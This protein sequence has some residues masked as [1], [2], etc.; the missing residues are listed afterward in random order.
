[1]PDLD[2]V[3]FIFRIPYK[4]AFGHR[5]ISHSIAFA[6]AIAFLAFWALPSRCREIPARRWLWTYLFLATVSHGVLDAFTNGG[7]GIAFFAPFDYDRYFFPVTPIEVSPLGVGFFS[8]RGFAVLLSEIQWVWLPSLLFALAAFAIRSG[9]NTR[10]NV[11]HEP[12]T[13]R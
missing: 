6:V 12:S 4:S 1:M 2:V 3:S 5:G 8:R 10:R 13:A 9:L 11:N 7:R